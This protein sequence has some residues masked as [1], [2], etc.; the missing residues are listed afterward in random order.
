NWYGLED[1]RGGGD[2]DFNDLAFRIT[3]GPARTLRDLPPNVTI[4]GPATG[5]V[6]NQNLTIAGVVS[7]DR[8]TASLQATVA[9]V[10]QGG[11]TT[12]VSSS[13]VTFNETTGAFSIATELALDGG[14][15]GSYRVQFVARDGAG[16]ASVPASLEFKL[17]TRAPA[18]NITAPSPSAIITPDSHLIGAADGTGSGL[19]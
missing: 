10:G 11:S 14:A 6:T 15:D 4:S 1:L 7:D 3:F 17:D 8:G 19:G 13:S 16:Q 12:T 9:K 2:R 18:V 5:T